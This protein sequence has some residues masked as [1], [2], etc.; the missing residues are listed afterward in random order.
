M[1]KIINFITN[2]K[3][4]GCACIINGLM[5]IGIIKESKFNALIAGIM[6]VSAMLF[7]YNA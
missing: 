6:F 4:L 2:N 5:Y 7:F 3:V 1:W